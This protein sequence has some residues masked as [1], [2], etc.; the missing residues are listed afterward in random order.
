MP[1]ILFVT[2]VGHPLFDTLTENLRKNGL[3]LDRLVLRPSLGRNRAAR[4]LSAVCRAFKVLLTNGRRHA[5]L[6]LH[7]VGLD[8]L[9]F[10]LAGVVLRKRIH[11][12]FWGSDIAKFNLLPLQVQAF[13][14]RSAATITFA[15]EAMKAAL[16]ALDA[17]LA[18]KTFI[19]PFGL[20][21]LSLIDEVRNEGAEGAQQGAPLIV[22]G[23]NASENQQLLEMI[24]HLEAF[25]LQHPEVRF[26]FPLN[27]GDE[28]YRAAVGARLATSALRYEIVERFLTGRELAKFRADTVILVQLQ[29]HDALSAAMLETL[30]AGGRVVTGAWLPYDIL[31]SRGVD[32]T[33]VQDLHE[34]PQ[35]LERALGGPM[36]AMRNRELV[37]ALFNWDVAG[38]AWASA[39]T[40]A[41]GKRVA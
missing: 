26:V 3:P 33:E 19:L 30:Y 11:L 20:E 12:H 27:Y 34:L 24:P 9:C 25:A 39:L 14:L 15:T 31:R 23:T 13:V 17:S 21:S 38:P 40:R 7:F 5:D 4:V 32:W 28:N 41:A 22:C 6:S 18:G 29:K 36:D 16:T 1:S 10:V 37:G 8:T 35:A 2:A